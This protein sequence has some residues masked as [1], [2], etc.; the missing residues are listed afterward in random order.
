MYRRQFL[1][2]AGAAG[3]AVATAGCVATGGGPGGSEATTDGSTPHPG[4]ADIDDQ[5]RRGDLG[6]HLVV[7]FED[8]SCPRCR[9]FERETVPKIRSNLVEA[10]KAAFVFRGYPVVYP[11]GEPASHALEATFARSEP[12]F[13]ALAEEYFAAQSQFSEGNVLDRTERFLDGRDDVDGT[14]VVDDVAE[15]A[16]DAAVQADLDAGENADVGATTPTVL[17]FRDGDYVSR[18][19]GSVSYDL[20]ATAL[21]EG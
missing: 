10:G 5:P 6:G 7:A 20:V 15:G 1:R 4:L 8:P 19:S 11:W 3:A 17:L 12:A 16:A 13:W 21:G 2:A 14:A 9:R 18:A